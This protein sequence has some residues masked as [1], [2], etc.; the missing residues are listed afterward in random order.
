MGDRKEQDSARQPGSLEESG[1][2]KNGKMGNLF[3]NEVE[4]NTEI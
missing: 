1:P 4:K 2:R 3:L